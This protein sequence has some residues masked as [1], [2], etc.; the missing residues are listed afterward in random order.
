MKTFSKKQKLAAIAAALTMVPMAMIGLNG[1]AASASA[2]ACGSGYH[3][4]TSFPMK[5]NGK[6]HGVAQVYQK[7]STNC[8]VLYRQGGTGYTSLA[9]KQGSKTV[10]SDAGTYSSLA[11]PLRISA[12]KCIDVRGL[13]KYNS[14]NYTGGGEIGPCKG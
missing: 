13:V 4:Y 1:T 9:L 7:G 14:T 5:H 12:Y 3:Y 8:V 10:V 2:A 6:Q 11:G